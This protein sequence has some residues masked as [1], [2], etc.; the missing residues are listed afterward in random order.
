MCISNTFKYMGSQ[1]PQAR[2]MAIPFNQIWRR[3]HLSNYIHFFCPSSR[4]N[5]NIVRTKCD[6]TW[7]Y[8]LHKTLL[9][10]NRFALAFEFRL[11]SAANQV[12][13]RF[14]FHWWISDGNYYLTIVSQKLHENQKKL[15]LLCSLYPPLGYV[16]W[17]SSGRSPM[18]QWR[19]Q[20]FP[21]GSA[22][23]VLKMSTWSRSVLE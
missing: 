11:S 13:G 14:I 23:A 7:K 17:C 12:H 15:C 6:Q 3:H 1:F 2:K 8:L 10:K 20:D 19:I 21:L 4:R 18:N 22:L 5:C 9:N 16:S